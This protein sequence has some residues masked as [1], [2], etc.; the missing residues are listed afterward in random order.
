MTSLH[1]TALKGPN[2]FGYMRR[3]L[4]LSLLLLTC[5]SLYAQTIT[6]AEYFVDTDP[7]FGNGT[8]ISVTPGSDVQL[9]FNV[10]TTS[11]PEGVHV[12]H[13]RA[14][15]SNGR[16]GIFQM[17]AFLV[18]RSGVALPNLVAVEYFFTGSGG[19]VS[20]VRT[21]TG[22]VPGT[23]I[24]ANFNAN[25]QGL[26]PDSLYTLNIYSRDANGG[27]GVVHRQSFLVSVMMSAAE[28]IRRNSTPT[29]FA[30]EQNYP[31]PFNPST[32]IRYQVPQVS[33][34]RLDVFDM[35]G[36]KVS[37]LVNERQ[38]AGSYQV[39]FN[40]TNLASGT[41]FYRLQAGVFV[42]TKKMLLVK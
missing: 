7:G 38:A 9:N 30:L 40:A 1:V 18:G 25:T 31:N 12:L 11:L 35:L 39:N 24:T 2:H 29:T 4:L 33:D 10:V 20:P 6:Q 37:T 26:Q 15:D 27:L 32:G 17:V 28:P 16:W 14:L 5:T 36:R 21:F 41:Y 23:D 8:A 34:V 22:F 19:F 13:V 3:L 42:E